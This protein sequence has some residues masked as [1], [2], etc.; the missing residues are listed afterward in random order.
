MPL[1]HF[2]DNAP[3]RE[4]L[5]YDLCACGTSRVEGWCPICEPDT[6]ETCGTYRVEGW[7]GVCHPC[8]TCKNEWCHSSKDH[9]SWCK[10]AGH[11]RGA[12]N[13]CPHGEMNERHC[14]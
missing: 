7:C 3:S 1:A 9:C 14:N 13:G 11:K 4:Q 6:C 5:L 12:K 2:F 10:Q 8:T